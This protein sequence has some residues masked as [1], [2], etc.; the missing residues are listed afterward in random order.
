MSG[1]AGGATAGRL[2]WL[3]PTKGV[4]MF[5]VVAY[6]VILYLQSAGVDAMLGRARAAFELFPMPAFFLLTGMFA[7]R[8]AQ[9]S[10]PALWR[11]RLLPILYLYVVFSVIRSLFTYLVPGMDLSFGEE[12]ATPPAELP[13]ILVWPRG[14]WFL[15]ALFLFTLLRWLI[16]RFPGWV[17]VAGSAIVSTLFS[18]GLVDVQNVGWNRVG[19]LF[20]FFVVGAVWSRQIRDLVARAHLGHLVAAGVVFVVVSVLILLGLRWIPFLALMGQVAAVAAGIMVVAR[21]VRWRL[22]GVFETLGVNSLKI[23]LLHMFIVAILVAPLPLLDPEGWPRW[24]AVA[25]QLI[26]TVVAAVA[27][28]ALARVTSRVRWLYVPPAFLRSSARS[29]GGTQGARPLP[30]ADG[31]AATAQQA[32]GDAAPDERSAPPATTSEDPR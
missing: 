21:L 4:A 18:T 32:V 2:A 3:E 15:F 17:Q 1:S 19:G 29:G 12:A 10:F 14:Y 30:S 25:V 20:F 7:A 13:L 27:A 6:H 8:Q 23:Y 31:S 22:I 5:M 24:L 28:L 26:Y 11:R 9:F 16:A